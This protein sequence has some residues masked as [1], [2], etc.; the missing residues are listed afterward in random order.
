[1]KISDTHRIVVDTCLGLGLK[2]RYW[3]LRKTGTGFVRLLS[4][5]NRRFA[6]IVVQDYIRFLLGG[7]R[8][9]EGQTPD[10]VRAAAHWLLLAQSATPDGGVSYGYFPCAGARGWGASYPETTGYI[11][12]SLLEFAQREGDEEVRE[13][14]LCMARWEIKVQMA[15]GAVQG[16]PVCPPEQ[17]T[18]A[19]F[20]TGMVLQGWSAAYRATGD[21]AFLA[22]GRRAADFLVRDLT[23]EGYFRTN[24]DFVTQDTIKTYNCLCAWPMY[25]FAQD[26]KDDCY[27]QAAI[28][29]AEA[30]MR[31]QRPNGWIA[32]NCLSRPE[33]PLL[34][35][36]GYALQGMLEVG[37][38]CKRSDF[39]DA[40]E[41]SVG[42]LMC[43]LSKKGF[44][45]GRYNDD[46]RPASFSSCLTGSA[47]LAVVCY[48]LF[49][50]TGTEK[51][52]EAANRV[53]NFLKA[54]QIVNSPLDGVNG[55]LAGSFP[56]CGSYMTLGYPN[57]AT[58][59]LLDSLMLQDR[60]STKGES[61]LLSIG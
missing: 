33:A 37:V 45:Y 25:C 18:P 40:V 1:M 19:A 41:R 21:R 14:A 59:Y 56:I 35:T 36:I 48:R 49:E 8:P 31:Q 32:N 39:I 17:Q 4:V 46:W 44:L 43:H 15:S 30:A 58:K 52:K 7:V 53:V 42:S 12:P 29:I 23:P 9:V 54:L 20:N 11:I 51:Y 60:L 16:G 34:H 27:Q 24:G 6:L 50:E 3:E 38:L 61:Q 2:E 10:R 47:Q 5:V 13:H 57:W 55:A 26:V 22:A 28:K